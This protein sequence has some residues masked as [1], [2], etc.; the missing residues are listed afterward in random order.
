M[1][2]VVGVWLPRDIEATLRVETDAGVG[3]A[4]IATGPEDPT[5]ITTVQLA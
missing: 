1:L 3:Q 4:P 5:C 2:A